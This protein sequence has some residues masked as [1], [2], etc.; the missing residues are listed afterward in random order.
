MSGRMVRRALRRPKTSPLSV[1]ASRPLNEILEQDPA[2]E[3]KM[4]RTTISC[5]KSETRLSFPMNNPALRHAKTA[6]SRSGGSHATE[7]GA[8][9]NLAAKSC[10]TH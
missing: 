6:V 3:R 1:L 10:V 7:R 5:R 2:G 4:G 8:R 9:K